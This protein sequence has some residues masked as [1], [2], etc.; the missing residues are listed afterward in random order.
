MAAQRKILLV[1]DNMKIMEGNVRKF[2]REGYDVACARTLVAAHSLV[3]KYYP[4]VIVLD[5][6]MPDGSGLE[7][8]KTI[9]Q[10]EITT[11]ILFLTGLSTKEDILCGIEAGGNDYL[12]KPYDFKELVARVAAL[13]KA[14]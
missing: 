12:T 11:P 5:I 3:G 13:I 8:A 9:R 7:F 10:D 14:V 6:M 1:E 4:D 2:T